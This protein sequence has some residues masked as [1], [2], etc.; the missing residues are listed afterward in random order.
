[1]SEGEASEEHSPPQH[2]RP[3]STISA[4]DGE[5][6]DTSIESIASTSSLESPSRSRRSAHDLRDQVYELFRQF[7]PD[8][9]SSSNDHDNDNNSDQQPGSPG[10]S[11][12]TRSVLSADLL[13]LLSAYEKQRGAPLVEEDAR[14]QLE[15]FCQQFPDHAIT[16]DDLIQMITKLEG[17]AR[18]NYEMEQGHTVPDNEAEQHTDSVDESR[19]SLS[20]G[21]RPSSPEHGSSPPRSQTVRPSCSSSN[22]SRA[23]PRPSRRSRDSSARPASDDSPEQQRSESAQMLSPPPKSPLRQRV[24]SD[25]ASP[26]PWEGPSQSRRRRS[27]QE[28]E[29]SDKEQREARDVLRGKGKGPPVSW[30]RPR[31]QALAALRNRRTSE[32]HDEAGDA[33]RGH[34]TVSQPLFSSESTVNRRGGAVPRSA[35]SG[36]IFP[37]ASSPYSPEGDE[38][39]QAHQEELWESQQSDRRS[40]SGSRGAGSPEP[41]EG[42]QSFAGMLSHPGSPQMGGNRG[43]SKSYSFHGSYDA[44]DAMIDPGRQELDELQKRYDSISKVLQEKERAYE[45]TQSA[46]ETQIAELETRVE[47]LQERHHT[48]TKTS[49]EMKQ[50][51]Q[52]YLDDISRFEGDLAASVKRADALER[53]KEV[54]QQDLAY[55][56]TTI[57]TLQGKVND[58]QDRILLADRE[59]AE[60]FSDQRE[61]EQA[62]EQYRQEI[63]QLRADLRESQEKESKV[64]ELETEKEAL[65]VQLRDLATDLEEARRGSGFVVTNRR[66]ANISSIGPSFLSKRLGNELLNDLA[67]GK[68]GRDDDDEG[69]A[70]EEVN[71]DESMES[72]VVTTTRRRRRAPKGLDGSADS[73]VSVTSTRTLSEVST[74][75]E[76]G[77]N[78]SIEPGNS[79]AAAAA[80]ESGPPSYDEAALEKSV[81]ARLHPVCDKDAADGVVSWNLLDAFSHPTGRGSYQMLSSQLGRRCAVLEEALESTSDPAKTTPSDAAT[82]S[83]RSQHLLIQ[84]A[85]VVYRRL[86]PTMQDAV[87]GR[88]GTLFLYSIGVLLLGLV[89]GSLVSTGKVTEHHHYSPQNGRLFEDGSDWQ[90]SNSLNFG[91]GEQGIEYASLGGGSD[92]AGLA[93]WAAQILSGRRA[94]T[95]GRPV[96]L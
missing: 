32:G 25:P 79:P 83:S 72:I 31:P 43:M 65:R 46:Q 69:S 89:L 27:G 2:G 78:A 8:Q 77:G 23:P 30:Q 96:A 70:D 3:L 82:T 54:M 59:E 64:E 33:G 16:C 18:R 80:T 39:W 28:K 76:R 47:D 7:V 5:E 9:G 37:R 81:I 35:S 26:S 84:G 14:P 19:S 90:L 86:P 42:F 94:A 58:L 92:E 67:E 74:Q 91:L 21:S 20:S 75:T 11:P 4:S 40:Q 44:Q 36:Y 53:V 57:A 1:M 10:L 68:S 66:D 95:S 49:D 51:E 12:G 88:R 60:H 29:S 22:G 55:R 71:A 6:Q 93:G 61:W 45:S 63:D 52:R 34:R 24:T 13:N 62:R 73:N 38:T 41:R 17:A 50:R 87:Q 48:L 56:E 85:S 15:A